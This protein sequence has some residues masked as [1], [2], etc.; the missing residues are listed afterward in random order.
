MPSPKS[1]SSSC[2]SHWIFKIL[3]KV[4]EVALNILFT[5]QNGALTIV[6]RVNN[7]FAKFTFRPTGS[8]LKSKSIKIGRQTVVVKKGGKNSRRVVLEFLGRNMKMGRK[9]AVSI[10]IQR[11]W[12]AQNNGQA[13]A[14]EPARTESIHFD[15]RIFLRCESWFLFK[16]HDS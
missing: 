16:N 6:L 2:L 15:S 1:K 13:W 12:S 7:L 5:I 10:S 9:R 14:R 11:K 3:F 8:I 4:L